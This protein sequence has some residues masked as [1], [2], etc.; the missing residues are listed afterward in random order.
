MKDNFKLTD[1]GNGLSRLKRIL[2]ASFIGL[3]VMLSFAVVA[4]SSGD[5][6]NRSPLEMVLRYGTLAVLI[7][8]VAY[9]YLFL[10]PKPEFESV[11]RFTKMLVLIFLA[12]GFN[13]ILGLNQQPYLGV[14]YLV[15][16]V[17]FTVRYYQKF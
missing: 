15:I 16:A 9:W 2:Y 17:L 10:T 6:S 1:I 7:S 11:T 13:G 8:L 12:L 5:F 3:I 4:M 14:T